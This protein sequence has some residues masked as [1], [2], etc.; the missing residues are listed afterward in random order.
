MFLRN[1]G[2]NFGCLGELP[3]RNTDEIR[4]QNEHLCI[5]TLGHLHKLIPVSI[6]C[7]LLSSAKGSGY[8]VTVYDKHEMAEVFRMQLIGAL[9]VNGQVI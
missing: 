5:E 2:S 1:H 4:H 3:Y 6:G 9:D 7:S 8:Q